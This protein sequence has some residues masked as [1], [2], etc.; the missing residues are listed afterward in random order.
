MR[1]SANPVTMKSKNICL[2]SWICRPEP[3]LEKN[4]KNAV[5]HCV[6]TTDMI[7]FLAWTERCRFSFSK[8]ERI[9]VME[10]VLLKMKKVGFMI[11]L[12]VFL[13]FLVL[14]M[15]QA[16]AVVAPDSTDSIVPASTPV[17]Y[18]EMSIAVVETRSCDDVECVISLDTFRE[19]SLVVIFR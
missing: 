1:A 15:R 12:L 2:K 11:K 5:G 18:D 9:L 6:K 8:K 4:R 3:A 19:I 14:W 13:S 7:P 17:A 16:V 10:R